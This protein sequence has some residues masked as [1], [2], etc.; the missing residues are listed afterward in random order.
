MR[1][2]PP[3]RSRTAGIV[4]PLAAA[5][6]VTFLCGTTPEDAQLFA[7]RRQ[8]IAGMTHSEVEQ[9][10]RNYEEFRK[11]SPERRQAIKELDDEVMHDASGH[12]LKLLTDY[13]K[14]LSSLSPFDQDRV[15]SKTDPIERAQLVK[16]IHDEQLKRQALAAIDGVGRQA[17]TLQPAELGTMLKAVQENFLSDASR[18]KITDQLT[19]RDLHLRILQAAFQQ[20]KNSSN[21]GTDS[22]TLISTL[23]DALPNEAIKTRISNRLP[24]RPRR[25]LLGQVLG[26]SLVNEWRKEIEEVFP[27]PAAIDAEVARRLAAATPTS[28]ETK[29]TQ[30]GTKQGRRMVGVQMVIASDEQFRDLRPVFVWLSAGL[31][32]KAPSRQAVLQEENRGEEAENKPKSAE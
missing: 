24:G 19:G 1:T 9:L 5:F 31:P 14:W 21:P 28:R 6:V 10:K 13:N 16:T 2:R 26:R 11:L 32:A 29:R 17:V 25:Q 4:G 12:M 15:L 18:K 22:Q 27:S 8:R 23:I 3:S 7:K 30:L 20:L